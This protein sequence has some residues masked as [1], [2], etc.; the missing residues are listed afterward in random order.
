MEGCCYC[1]DGADEEE[2]DTCRRF[3]VGG[4]HLLWLLGCDL[5]GMD[6]LLRSVRRQE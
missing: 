5:V 3:E 2:H 6:G 1:C 4:C